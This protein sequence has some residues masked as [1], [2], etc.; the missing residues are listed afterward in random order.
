MKIIECVPNFSEGRDRK[1]IESI[2]EAISSSPGVV[3]LDFDPGYDT[4]RTVYSFVGAPEHILT[5]ACNAVKRGTELIDMRF[6]TGA[7][8]RIGAC[9]VCPFI[10]VSGVSMGE[11]VELAK[12]LGKF[13]GEEL[14]IPVFLYEHAAASPERK[15]LEHIRSGQ[16]EGLHD[17]LIRPEW[18]P[19]Y[20]PS[21]F[22]DRVRK[23]GATVLGARDFLI[24]YNININ[25][26]DRALACE[27]AHAIR[28]KGKTVVDAE[29]K[30]VHRAGILKQC[31]A[32]GWYVEEYRR[33]QISINL[34]NY[35]VTNLH[36]AFEAASAEASSRGVRVTGSEIVG[37]VP[38]KALIDAGVYYLQKQGQTRALSEKDIIITAVQSLGLSELE[39][40]QP[41]KKIIEYRIRAQDRLS[42]MSLEDFTDELA[43]KSQA[44]GGGS[45]S[46][47]A[48]AIAAALAAM[49]GN[50]T[51]KKKNYQAVWSEAE[52]IA[53][54]CFRMKDKFLELIDEDTRA[55]TRYMSIAS[56]EKKI[57]PEK[58]RENHALS[59]A[60]KETIQVP[61][62]MMKLSQKLLA[63]LEKMIKIGN[64][65]TLSEM[66]ISAHMAKTA[67]H[68]AHYN[69]L[70]NLKE[71]SD[72]H[73]K[74]QL[75][76]ETHTL[77][78]KTDP[79]LHML[80]EELEKKMN[81]RRDGDS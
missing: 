16:Y 31:K 74:K 52:E 81:P 58:R 60:L 32:I 3:L 20:G 9:D 61:Y 21:E 14:T 44:P 41:D 37:L 24:A 59:E 4:N 19:D 12:K 69:I 35:H 48:G 76:E 38:K 23:T 77:V 29:G 56:Q 39:P 55:F 78:K 49:I 33:A 15:N 72:V 36:H 51:Y 6:H 53:A 73:L 54:S 1:I 57:A 2:A 27:I 65:N 17:K 42:A 79:A 47:L 30:R 71:L 13:V 7:H 18:K 46:A 25:S 5:A 22:N 34:T 45:V 10:P 66:A 70:L 11:C 8:P 26:K 43:S 50:L 62:E 67:L 28:E 64:T 40:F 75:I 63:L 68:G 80:I